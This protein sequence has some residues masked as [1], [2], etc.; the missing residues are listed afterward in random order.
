MRPF[1]N[2]SSYPAKWNRNLSEIDVTFNLRFSTL[3]HARSTFLENAN[4]GPAAGKTDRATVK[5]HDGWQMSS[6]LFGDHGTGTRPYTRLALS[7]F[8]DGVV[9][10][11]IVILRLLYWY[12]RTTTAGLSISGTVLQGI[13]GIVDNAGWLYYTMIVPGWGVGT[14]ILNIIILFWDLLPVVFMLQLISPYGMEDRWKGVKRRVWTHRE[15]ASRRLG[16]AKPLLPWIVVSQ[17]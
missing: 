3:S 17:D 4:L 10:L 5:A 12:T 8:A 11:S 9:L 16:E 7:F 14:L 13:S 15:R 1:C 6:G 2:E